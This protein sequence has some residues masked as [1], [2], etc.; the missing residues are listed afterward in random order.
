MVGMTSQIPGEP[1][2]DFNRRCELESIRNRDSTNPNEA[3]REYQR[4]W[5]YWVSINWEN[6]PK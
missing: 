6:E 5:N 2:S 4:I 1:Q 3:E